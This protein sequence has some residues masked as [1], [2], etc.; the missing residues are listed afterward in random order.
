MV[1]CTFYNTEQDTA[2]FYADTADELNKL[3]NLT[4]NGRDELV[5]INTVHAGSTCLLPNGVVY[6]L[7][8]DNSWRILG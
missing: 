6:I 7:G 1:S 3:P 8:G 5:N 2:E 4:R